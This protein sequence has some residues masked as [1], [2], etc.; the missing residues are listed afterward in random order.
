MSFTT[1]TTTNIINDM[2]INIVTNVD[3]VS[4]VNPGSVLRQLTEALSSE[5]SNLY[6]E[7]E[8]V[9]EGTRILTATEDD[10]ENLGAIVGITRT[11]GSESQGTITFIRETVATGDF[12]IPSGSIISTNPALGTQ[13][14]FTLDA[15]TLFDSNI[16]A[17]SITYTDGVY[18]YPLSQKWIGSITT[19]TGTAA[20]APYVFIEATDFDQTEID[21]EYIPDVTSLVEVDTCEATATWVAS[22]DATAIATDAVNF[23]QGSNSLKLGKNGGASDGV[24]Y[25]KPLA[26]TVDVTDKRLFIWIRIV[27]AAALAKITSITLRLSSNTVPTNN[28]YEFTLSDL[29]V[30][31]KLYNIGYT[32]TDTTQTG[33]PNTDSIASIRIDITVDA[34]ATLL[35]SGDVNIDYWH[36]T[37]ADETYYGEVIEFDQT[38]TLP[39]DATAF[40]TTWKP[41]SVDGLATAQAIGINYNVAANSIVYKVSAIANI[42]SLTNYH[43]LTGGTAEED[44]DALRTRIQS[45]AEAAAKA[46]VTAIEQNLLAVS[47]IQSIT[48]DD[49]PLLEIYGPTGGVRTQESYIMN[50]AVGRD[51]IKFEVVYL[52]DTTAPT[53]IIV[54]NA[55]DDIVADYVYGTASDYYI[56]SDTNEIVWDTSNPGVSCPA[57]AAT[58]Y[59]GY[60]ANW[61]GHVQVYAAGY[62]SPLSSAISTAVDAA[63][64]A[65]KAAGIDV[66]WEEATPNYINIECTVTI[67]TAGGYSASEV[68]TNVQ[69]ALINWLNDKDIGDDVLIAEFYEVVMNIDGATNVE[70]TDWDGDVVAPFSDVS[71]GTNEVARPE[72]GGIIVN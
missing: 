39:D 63:I 47:G 33:Y 48:V 19:M 65:V 72:D 35:D 22:A 67:D 57:N 51:K 55:Y 46:T 12:T 60:Q 49:L 4:D 14:K 37:T 68:K 43:S 6:D 3:Q 15:D 2:I 26:A 5:V 40:L 10:L 20:A 23:K 66:D 31:W 21:G 34:A 27:D 28:Y 71:I 18:L 41:L 7:L 54:A 1:K 42:S 45:A 11:A 13:Y 38:G 30:G 64:L 59:V 29:E 9:Y 53:N 58:Y 8:N 61:L 69:T 50:T 44:D 56:D 17:E 32:D 16:A 70:I 25:Y 52:D 24:S 62:A 36:S